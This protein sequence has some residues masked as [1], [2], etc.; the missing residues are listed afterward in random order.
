M[1]ML[2]YRMVYVLD[3]WSH[4]DFS[5]SCC[6]CGRFCSSLD[7]RR[8]SGASGDSPR[9]RG[10]Y[11]AHGLMERYWRALYDIWMI[12]GWWFS[13]HWEGVIGIHWY[14][15]MGS[16]WVY[17]ANNIV[18]ITARPYGL[19]GKLERCLNMIL[20][21]SQIPSRGQCFGISQ[22]MK[23]KPDTLNSKTI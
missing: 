23:P 20:R 1:V 14:R 3:R 17:T 12:Y 18:N 22:T 2:N 5:S 13:M 15:E 21:N 19:P 6:S 8:S 4:G 9:Y 16:H 7:R 11:E 10:G